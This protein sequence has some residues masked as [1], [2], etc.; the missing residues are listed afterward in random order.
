MSTKFETLKRDYDMEKNA[1]DC[2]RVPV[3][4]HP[5]MHDS[6]NAV[7]ASS[8]RLGVENSSNEATND[9]REGVDDEDD[10][11][12]SNFDDPLGG[13][14]LGGGD[15]DPLGAMG[16]DVST[17]YHN[18]TSE[19][20]DDGRS[21]GA[22]KT[23]VNDM[24][25]EQKAFILKEYT[26]TGKIR[27]TATFM[28]G[29]GTMEDVGPKSEPMDKT[30]AR[31]EKLEEKEED[32]ME[33]SQ[34]EYVNRIEEL[35]RQLTDAW[36]KNQRV[37]AL[38]IAIQCA[39]MML[40]STVIQFYPSMFVLLTE[41]LETFGKLVFERLKSRSEEIQG[42]KLSD[43]FTSQ[44][45][46][47]EAKETCRNWFYKTACIREL[48]PRVY[49]ELCV[50]PC[51][52]FL[53]DGE[54]K[55]I[56]N[57]ISNII[58]GVG[59]PLVALWARVYLT[60]VGCNIL[61]DDVSF[62]KSALYDYLFTWS[63]FEETNEYMIKLL[64]E[65]GLTY[66]EYLKLHEPALSWLCRAVG[67]HATKEDFTKVLEHYRDYCGN[68]LV[69]KHIILH[70]NA[71]FWS[72]ST[73]GM[74]QLIKDAKPSNVHSA[75]LYEALGKG[76]S[77]YPPP[78]NQRMTVLN[79]SWK[80]VT[81]FTDLEAYASCAATWID[82]LLQHYQDKH[83]LILLKD[84]VRHVRSKGDDAAKT[85]VT[86]LERVVAS[87]TKYSS[88]FGEILTSQ[89][90]LQLLDLFQSERK[91]DM[92]KE[93]LNNFIS[94]KETTSDPVVIATVFDIARSLHDSLDSLSVD[95]ERRQISNLLCRFIALIDFKNNLEQ[96]LNVLV[97]CRAAFP[98]LDSVK[99]R[100]VLSVVKLAVK[101]H[102]MM[103]GKHTRKT[104]AFVKACFAY[105]HITIPSIDDVFRRLYLF[106]QCGQVALMNN[107]L[108]Q[109]D[110]FFKAAISE[111]PDIPK[112]Y[113]VQFRSSKTSTEPMLMEF[114][115]T[116][117]ASLIVVP[118]HPEHGPFY[119]VSGLRNAIS[120]YSWNKENLGNIELL[121]Y[122][123][124]V[125][126]SWSQRRL[127]YSIEQVDSN[128]VLFGGNE[129]F[130][131]E[132][133]Q[134]FNSILSEILQ[135]LEPSAN[136]DGDDDNSKDPMEEPSSKF[137][138]RRSEILVKLV[139][140]LVSNT[141]FSTTKSSLVVMKKILKEIREYYN[142][143][144]YIAEF[145]QSTMAYLQL[146]SEESDESVTKKGL[147]G[148]QREALKLL[149][150]KTQ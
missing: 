23:N 118:G 57:R 40:D 36:R 79:E 20:E 46:A 78:A 95:D 4:Y 71:S 41:V 141:D 82:M 96:Q 77:K 148:K 101:A 88:N 127:P 90:F 15:F 128:D 144:E 30:K 139:N 137:M 124:P 45:V 65:K 74:V 39:K 59:D 51:Y 83:V 67:V 1:S 87:V 142:N 17:Q 18:N 150:N 76:M 94:S 16:G 100:L 146:K 31:L 140:V 42:K 93:L 58:R 92:C 47:V 117:L 34:K 21:T 52:R 37:D 110:T 121:L 85:I 115:E 62:I 120:K 24:W 72:S 98:N 33:V 70:F 49:I 97:D 143:N 54:F 55:V 10:D 28:T 27:V 48:L 2:Q 105:C 14:V 113:T 66:N 26:V 64:K 114:V 35:H 13:T 99:D 129:M 138:K 107:C 43:D 44:D 91:T 131:N 75:E 126:A 134:H 29:N 7:S 103:K 89:Y 12:L 116:F 61:S 5:L 25:D 50:T 149:L 38:K 136:D 56:L 102:V 69:L 63:Q 9:G 19:E 3:S 108:P 6:E 147:F 122:M 125:L 22:G 111:I 68:T 11:P 112:T 53:T 73:A 109:T 106:L 123:L 130:L 80:I 104:S 86:P 81:K 84:L 145:Y 135:G 60:R 133:K 32:T 8:V 132:C 119:L